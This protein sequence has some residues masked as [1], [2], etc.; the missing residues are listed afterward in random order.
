EA[1]VKAVKFHL[2]RLIGDS[3]LTYEEFTTL[4]TRIE[5]ILNSRPLCPLS[6]DPSDLEA[7]TPAHFL[8]GC[9]LT[10]T[11][12]PSLDK[13]PANR[14]SRWQ[15]LQQLMHRF[16]ARWQKEYLQRLQDIS[17]WQTCSP[18]ISIGQLVL[19]KDERVPPTKWPLAR[20]IQTHAGSN[21]LIRVATIRTANSILKRPIVKLCPPPVAS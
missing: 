7:L 16:W 10:T 12:E 11:P 18:S 6:D 2:K 19:L 13:E 21:G 8:I 5:A 3:T 17:K 15:F 20:V 9:P 14:L 4:L 1:A